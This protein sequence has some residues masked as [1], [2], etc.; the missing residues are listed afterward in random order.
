MAQLGDDRKAFRVA[1]KVG[2]CR[3][4][5]KRYP[6]QVRVLPPPLFLHGDGSSIGGA[7]DCGSRGCGFE[8]RPSPFIKGIP[9]DYEQKLMDLN[10]QLLDNIKKNYSKLEKLLADITGSDVYEDAV[11]RFYHGSYKVYYVQGAT[12]KIVN[13]LKDIAPEG[14]T[15][16]QNFMKIF[17]KGTGKAFKSDHNKEWAKHTQPMLEAFFHAK[18]FLE[19]AVKFG[20]DLD[21]AP[22]CLPFGWAGLLYLYNMR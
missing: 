22:Q 17:K 1:V 15:L 7:L 9:M 13:T 10:Q 2:N 4:A 19:M 3:H 21:K 8:S 18:Y 11:Y 12:E 5:P 6:M 14:V 16:N 20:K